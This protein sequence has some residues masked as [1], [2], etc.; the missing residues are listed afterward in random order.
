MF[1]FL[2][3]FFLLRLQGGLRRPSGFPHDSCVPG[4]ARPQSWDAP[5]GALPASGS[6]ALPRGFLVRMRASRR[7]SAPWAVRAQSLRRKPSGSGCFRAGPGL[8]QADPRSS[9]APAGWVA[10]RS[11]DPPPD[12]GHQ[13]H[14]AAPGRRSR[15]PRALPHFPGENSALTHP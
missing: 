8:R 1:L 5:S 2:S 13:A 4:E 9:G 10:P 12:P 6:S 15:S 3:L 7:V 14:L 11:C